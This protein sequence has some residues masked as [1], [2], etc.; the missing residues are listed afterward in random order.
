[1]RNY[2]PYI[3]TSGGGGGSGTIDGTLVATHVP[4]ALDADTL[5]TDSNF[6][7]VKGTDRLSLGAGASP[8]A[9]LHVDSNAASTQAIRTVENSVGIYSEFVS[10]GSP[11]GVITGKIGD[12]CRDTTN[13][14]TYYKTTGT[15]ASPTNTGWILWHG[16]ISSPRV[17]GNLSGA[18]DY[19]SPQLVRNI[20]DSTQQAYTYD[21]GGIN[22]WLDNTLFSQTAEKAVAN[23]V[24]ETS[25]FSST[26]GEFIGT[27]TLP[28][29]HFTKGKSLHC[30]MNGQ[31]LNTGTPSITIKVK[32][33][34][35]T[36][37]DSG[38]IPL[39]TILSTEIF[40]LDVKLKCI[41][42]GVSGTVQGFLVLDFDTQS[43]KVDSGA[44]GLDTT[45]SHAFDITVQWDTASASNTI[46][47]KLAE[48][49]GKA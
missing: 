20:F 11:E 13:G 28:N 1:M 5:E 36:I 35:V 15:F 43:I 6:L 24:A 32:L 27:R 8:L 45:A 30:K 21:I 14:A 9:P 38:A 33:G 42:A 2:I 40:T 34:A 31:I 17:M 46:T 49:G 4:F 29:N 41:S 19:P 16:K 23:T 12:E 39:A 3:P 25:L 44:V 47:N 22:Q 26:A 48:V 7:Y 37:L 18:S 10:N